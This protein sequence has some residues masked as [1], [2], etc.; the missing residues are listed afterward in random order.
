MAA[1]GSVLGEAAWG[2]LARRA[3]AA[4]AVVGLRQQRA[5]E[6][7]PVDVDHPCPRGRP[8]LLEADGAAHPARRLVGVGQLVDGGAVAV[9]DGERDGVEHEPRPWVVQH[10]LHAARPR[11]AVAGQAVRVGV[12]IHSALLAALEDDETEKH[13][14][15]GRE[16]DVRG[17]VAHQAPAARSRGDGRAACDSLSRLGEALQRTNSSDQGKPSELW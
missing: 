6:R 8:T 5:V 2:E 15:Y 11:T 7:P 9:A 12:V 16:E 10:A 17:W 14:H 3:V 1:Q 13:E 4:R